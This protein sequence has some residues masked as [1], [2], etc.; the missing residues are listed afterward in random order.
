MSTLDWNKTDYQRALDFLQESEE[1]TEKEVLYDCGDDVFAVLPKGLPALGVRFHGWIMLAPLP[2]LMASVIL[3]PVMGFNR[4]WGFSGIPLAVTGVCVLITWGF[5]RVLRLMV[6]SRDIFPRKYFVTLGRQGIAM[7]FS[8][9][10]FPFRPSRTFIPW[11][12]V[13]E[14]R[15][16]TLCFFPGLLLG[17]PRIPALELLGKDGESVV[18]P[19]YLR[20]NRFQR[21]TERI[22]ELIE[23]K[24]APQ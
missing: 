3:L 4:G 8:K 16:G 21:E 14:I 12:E 13:K 18:L 22:K 9:F 24:L 15:Q 20:G 1:N 11:K 6:R 5:S 19:F 7:H 17:R 2:F 23:R 10:H